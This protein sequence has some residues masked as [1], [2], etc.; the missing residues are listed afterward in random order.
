MNRTMDGGAKAFAVD[1]A[2]SSGAAPGA[3]DWASALVSV[4]GVSGR[5][6]SG[7]GSGSAAATEASTD[8][9]MFDIVVAACCRQAVQE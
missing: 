6:A 5:A 7:S 9:S 3:A 8:L 2:R 4:A 1:E